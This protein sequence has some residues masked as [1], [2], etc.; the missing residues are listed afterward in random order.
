MHFTRKLAI[1]SIATLLL[2]ITPFLNAGDK[3]PESADTKASECSTDSAAYAHGALQHF[4][5]AL[6][7][8]NVDFP[9]VA[10]EFM[11]KLVV[12]MGFNPDVSLLAADGT[13]TALES[14]TLDGKTISGTVQKVVAP[15]TFTG[16]Y[17]YMAQIKI[18]GTV[19]T[20]LYWS[21]KGTSSKGFLIM[22]GAGFKTKT[23][24]LYVKWD[25]T[26]TTQ[27]VD[28]L[29]TRIGSGTYLSDPTQ[30]DA[31]YGSVSYDTSTK[32]TTVQ[33]VFL[34]RQ[35]GSSPSTTVYACF[36]MYAIGTAG[37]AMRV[38]KTQDSLS[39][40]GHVKTLVTQDGID[41]M[42]D[43]EGNDTKTEPNGTGNGTAVQGMAMK[44]SCADLNGASASGKPFEGNAANHS[45]TKTQMDAMYAAN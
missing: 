36:K 35:R 41:E 26:G 21:G 17:D 33:N 7:R 11:Y 15:N 12:K 31:I 44:Y 19:F 3:P 1:A 24:I 22:G 34:G 45:M 8:L 38:G 28:V 20:T 23:H 14:K 37:A 39:T 6:C 25:R 30:D 43:W 32:A 4:H 40:S 16:T 2:G 42:D 9:A 27:T 10:E 5:S 13:P 29:G 18:G